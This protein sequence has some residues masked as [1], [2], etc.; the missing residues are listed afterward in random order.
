MRAPSPAPASAPPLQFGLGD[1]VGA[2]FDVDETLVTVKSMFRF[3]AYYW[4]ATGQPPARYEAVAAEFAGLPAQG[5][6]REESNRRFYRLFAGDRA[7]EVARHG[8]EWFAAESARPGFWQRAGVEAF[9]RHLAAGHH[10]VLVSG[11][12][13]P[14]LDP[15]ARALGA[16]TVLCSEPEIVD[17]H[18][19]GRLATPMIGDAKGT[20][21]RSLMR[22]LGLS[23]AACHAYG[24]HSSDLPLLAQ[25]GHPVAVGDDPVLL[26]HIRTHGGRRLAV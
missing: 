13:R 1:P 17:G 26:R 20:A 8:R 7:E 15:L 23:P 16:H 4:A 18:Y 11:S 19:T 3:L 22:R 6:T 9:R 10:T 25:V 12:F 2:F 21:A 24:D 5:V 14:C